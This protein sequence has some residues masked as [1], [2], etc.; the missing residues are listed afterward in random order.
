PNYGGPVVY[1]ADASRA[2]GT[3]SSLLS[4]TQRDGYAATT[5]EEYDRIREAYLNREESADRYPIE[6]ARERPAP[7]DWEG[8]TPPAPGQLGVTAMT[9]PLEALLHRMDWTPF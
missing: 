9:V 2:V 7:V 4:A 1:V 6:E 5:R 8:Y 3:V